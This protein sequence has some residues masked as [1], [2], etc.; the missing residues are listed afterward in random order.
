MTRRSDET[1]IIMRVTARGLVPATGG[2]AEDLSRLRIGSDVEVRPL[3]ATRSKA[4]DAWWLLCGRTAEALA[5]QNTK[6]SVSN[7]MLLAMNMVEQ[8]ALFG[9]GT[10]RVPMSLTDFDDEQLWRLVEAGKLHVTTVLIPG[11][12]IDALLKSRR[13]A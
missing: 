3:K 1:A 11:V 8:E 4:L 12:D 2:D 13:S 7:N 5:D 10:R 9:G 6:R